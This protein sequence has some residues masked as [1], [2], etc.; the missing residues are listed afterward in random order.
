[1][2]SGFTSGMKN[3]TNQRVTNGGEHLDCPICL[4]C[5]KVRDGGEGKGKWKC[6]LT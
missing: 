3:Q 4:E 6:I 1:M 5:L 2:N